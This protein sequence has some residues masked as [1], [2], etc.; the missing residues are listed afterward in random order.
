[1]RRALL[2]LPGGNEDRRRALL[3]VVEHPHRIA[4][5][6]RHM[7]VDDG[8]PAGGLGVAVR[9]GHD[10]GFLQAEDVTKPRIAG[11]G[12]HQRQLGGAWVAENHLDALLGQK[13]EQRLLARGHRHLSILRLVQ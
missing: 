5:T 2:V 4:E 7:Q 8:E 3:R 11:Q 10:H 9:H 1:M 13:I 6:G 12:V